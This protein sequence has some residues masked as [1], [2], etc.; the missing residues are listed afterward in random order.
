VNGNVE[1]G[2]LRCDTCHGTAKSYAPPP[3]VSGSSD[4]SRIGVGA[5][6]TH[7][8][9][10]ENGR[11]LACGECHVVPRLASY[12]DHI[13]GT[14]D[15][16]FSGVASSWGAAPA[17]DPASA[18]CS[19]TWCHGPWPIGASAAP[20]PSP[21]WTSGQAIGCAPA[22]HG[23]PP[24][25]PHLQRTDCVLCHAEVAEG[26]TAPIVDRTLHVDGKVS[27]STTSTCTSCHE[28]RTSFTGMHALHLSGGT[29]SSPATC[30]DCHR[31]VQNVWDTGHLDGPLVDLTRGF[32]V[33]SGPV[34][35]YDAR[36]GRCT[37]TWC[38]G[39]AS[40]PW[41]TT[42]TGMCSASCHGFP[43]AAPHPQRTDCALCHANVVEDDDATIKDRT[44]HVNR[45]V[46]YETKS[47]CTDCHKT[48]NLAPPP[49]LSGN[50]SSLFRGVGAHDAH[51]GSSQFSRTTACSDCHPAVR[52][53]WD[54]G[55]LDGKTDVVF[56][57]VATTYGAKPTWDG[58]SCAGTY[59]H[60]R[61]GALEPNP[62]WAVPDGT[63][64]VCGGCHSNP[65]RAGMHPTATPSQCSGCH[66]EI[67]TNM[68]VIDPSRHVDGVVS[69]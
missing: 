22:C 23:L 67:D 41:T 69:Y 50:T 62:S 58:S 52:N 9:G 24:P 53:V 64:A 30:K 25:A 8:S 49:D 42:A 18:T 66:S 44:L 13:D 39:A 19:N 17:W 40:P 46:D 29:F 16:T 31:A 14:A 63:K 48:P 34:P 68:N 60:S 35:T 61:S 32:P 59:C 43:P 15:V 51:L 45:V 10:G 47:A 21:S 38:H 56:S 26:P 36:T 4:T 20:K 57:G 33:T 5:H 2:D 54:E 6:Q 11:P 12:R 65:P 27:L 28:D 55:H 7:L 1:V 3:D 37:S